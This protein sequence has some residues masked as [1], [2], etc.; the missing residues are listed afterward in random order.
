MISAEYLM[1]ILSNYGDVVAMGVTSERGVRVGEFAFLMA[2]KREGFDGIPDSIT[3]R[4]WRMTLVVEGHR[5]HCWS[6]RQRGHV[7]RDCPQRANKPMA[8]T[9][10]VTPAAKPAVE[11]VAAPGKTNANPAP[12]AGEGWSEVTRK[13]RKISHTLGTSNSPAKST[14][15]PSP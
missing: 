8:A 12:E 7:A 10:T 4:S 5:P 15:E 1:V 2:L 3:F 9:T 13:G 14:Q 6:C 11:A